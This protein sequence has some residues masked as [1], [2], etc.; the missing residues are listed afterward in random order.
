MEI[1][2]RTIADSAQAVI[3]EEK[4]NAWGTTKMALIKAFEDHRPYEDII[5]HVR[6]TPYQGSISKFVNELKTRSSKGLYKLE[7]KP[8]Q[9]DRLIYTSSL[10]KTIRDCI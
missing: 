2:Q 7:F 1:H 9:T 6:D 10:I 4:S 5:Q 8:D 3:E